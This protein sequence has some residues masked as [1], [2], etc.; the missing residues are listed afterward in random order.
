MGLNPTYICPPTS[1][2]TIHVVLDM[3]RL[4]LWLEAFM[5]L[6]ARFYASYCI[7]LAVSGFHHFIGLRFL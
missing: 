1:P 2:G 3:S 4:H 6:N 5:G 7:A